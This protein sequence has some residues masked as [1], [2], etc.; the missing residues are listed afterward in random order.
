MTLDFTEC[1]KQQ[2]E[3]LQLD[4]PVFAGIAEIEDSIALRPTQGGRIIKTYYDNEVD[5]GLNY[6][7][8][9]K[10]KKQKEAETSML[11]ISSY[12]E[13][14]Q[15]IQ[16]ENGSFEFNQITVTSES[17]YLGENEDGFFF[18][19]LTIEANLTIYLEGVN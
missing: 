2:I 7:F 9:V 4:F 15:D 13:N 19:G 11:A 18:Y 10:T 12:L 6:E 5:K 17:F 8:V 1:L 16:S 14:L 3:S